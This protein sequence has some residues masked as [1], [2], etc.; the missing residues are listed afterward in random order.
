MHSRFHHRIA[1]CTG[2]PALVHAIEKSHVLVL[3]W[4]YNSLADFHE[5]PKRW[6][7]D[8]AKVLTRGDPQA[9]DAKMRDHVR[10]ALDEM[11][12]R[13]EAGHQLDELPFRSYP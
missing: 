10:Y 8:L 5:L 1:E 2:C 13:L 7:R 12:R 3:N 11:L 9:A 4:L 6:H